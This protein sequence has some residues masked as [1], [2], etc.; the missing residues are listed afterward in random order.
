[1]REA[2]I[3]KF[4]TVA[5]YLLIGLPIFMLVSHFY[6]LIPDFD[7]SEVVYEADPMENVEIIQH[8]DG[9]WQFSI[10]D[11]KDWC[12]KDFAD[13]NWEPIHIPASWESQGFEGYNGYAW[14]RKKILLDKQLE[15]QHLNLH[16]GRID[17]A[18]EVYIDGEL[19]GKSGQFPPHYTTAFKSRRTYSVPARLTTKESITIAIR[20]F[21]AEFEG[22]ILEGPLGFSLK[23][24]ASYIDYSLEGFWDFRTAAENAEKLPATK[25]GWSPVYV[26]AKWEGQGFYEYDGYAWYKKEFEL[27]EEEASE[28]WVLVL[29]LID[30]VDQTYING[31]MVGNTGM[32]MDWDENIVGDEWRKERAYF[33]PSNTLQ[34]GMNTVAV[35]VFDVMYDGGMYQGPVGLVKQENYTRFWKQKQV[36]QLESHHHEHP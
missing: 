30:D 9:K 32:G 27:S 15:G 13:D 10:L 34:A 5:I 14:Y 22:G 4:R 11:N 23:E 21:D 29:G 16:L 3:D 2:I 20:V 36:N 33:V 19:I 28:N 8:I 1:M 17:D 31:K 25:E 26:P 12:N 24:D 35:R 18:D 7:Q 6:D